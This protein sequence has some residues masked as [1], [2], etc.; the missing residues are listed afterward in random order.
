MVKLSELKDD[1]K[2]IDGNSSVYDVEEIK[3]DLK[4]WKNKAVK[5]YTT[6]EYHANIDARDM[7]ESAIESE[8]SNDM[9]DDWDESILRDITDEDVKKIQD[10]LDE[11]F[12]RN[13]SQNIAY[14]QGEEIEID[15]EEEI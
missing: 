13:K 5:L 14:C 9:Y 7:L 1:V 2:V 8:Y 6:T 3:I 10:V 12:S 11:I 15:L 4:W